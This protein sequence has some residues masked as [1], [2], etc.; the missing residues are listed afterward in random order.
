MGQ[1]KIWDDE[2][3]ISIPDNDLHD[4]DLKV[5]TVLGV[6]T[7]QIREDGA[8]IDFF[9][10]LDDNDKVKLAN[11]PISIFPEFD[12]EKTIN[13]SDHPTTLDTLVDSVLHVPTVNFKVC[14]FIARIVYSAEDAV[15]ALFTVRGPT[16]HYL[17]YRSTFGLTAAEAENVAFGNDWDLPATAS[18]HSQFED[19]NL[20]I[21]E[22][23]LLPSASGDIWI[24]FAS[25]TAGKEVAIKAG[26]Y[27][28]T[29]NFFAAF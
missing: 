27:L 25:G 15:G 20:A 7:L 2:E 26:S 13:T 24:E 28:F 19:H 12:T 16:F 8:W 10:R 6:R 22:G 29:E 9:P 11:L 3:T 17:A 5:A 14:H 4:G 23:M 18:D 21:V 1:I